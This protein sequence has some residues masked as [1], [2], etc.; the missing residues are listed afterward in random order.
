MPLK[1]ATKVRQ[2]DENGR[3]R[4]TRRVYHE[5]AQENELSNVSRS[6]PGNDGSTETP[7]RSGGRYFA[8]DW[9]KII[10]LITRRKLDLR[11]GGHLKE[12]YRR[13]TDRPQ[14]ER[15]AQGTKQ[16]SPLRCTRIWSVFSD[17]IG[18]WTSEI[19]S[20]LMVSLHVHWL[21]RTN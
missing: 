20:V 16:H 5:F 9:A 21:V 14:V 7:E 18:Q 6:G 17:L 13:P 1:E 11:H 4:G 8:R 19:T 10:L 2:D 12:E 15:Y 3:N